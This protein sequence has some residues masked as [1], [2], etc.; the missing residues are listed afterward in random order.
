MILPLNNSI[1]FADVII[2]RSSDALDDSKSTCPNFLYI[3]NYIVC[4]N[5][6]SAACWTNGEIIK[7]K[8]YYICKRGIK[9]SSN[10][11]IY[12]ETFQDVDGV[13]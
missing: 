13:K 10:V 3:Y 2:A 7:K 4:S 8:Y 12:V 5:V 6:V 11:S 9:K 1:V